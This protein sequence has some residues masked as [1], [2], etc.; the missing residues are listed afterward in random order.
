[1]RKNE[2]NYYEKTN[3]IEF[4]SE[5]CTHSRRIETKTKTSNKE[6][7]ISFRKESSLN[8]LNRFKFNDSIKN[9][10]KLIKIVTKILFRKDVFFDQSI[11]QSTNSLSRKDQKSTKSIKKMKTSNAVKDF[12]LNLNKLQ[13][14]NSRN[15]KLFEINIAMIKASTFNMINKRKNVNLFS[16]TLK[17]VKKHLKK[18]N[19]SNIVIKNVLSFE[20]HEFLDVFNKKTF[21]IFV[22]HWFY[23]HKIILKQN[24]VSSYTLLY[25]MSEE[26]LKIIK[27]E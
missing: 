25:K 11:D 26:K 6:K 2:I 1:M 5:F 4:V 16:I 15:K 13:I 7:N 12:R 8:Q 3:I 20:Y 23:D 10:T 9:S 18:R 27:K 14:S 19:K 22:S 21:N 17:N 24:A